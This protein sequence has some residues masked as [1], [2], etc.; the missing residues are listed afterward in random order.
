MHPFPHVN[1][2]SKFLRGG[3]RHPF[4]DQVHANLYLGQ[5]VVVYHYMDLTMQPFIINLQPCRVNRFM[6]TKQT[7]TVFSST[8]KIGELISFY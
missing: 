6:I 2:K 4:L 5:W 3:T 7:K 1:A 8:D